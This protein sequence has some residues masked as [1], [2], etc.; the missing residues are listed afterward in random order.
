MR[1]GSRGSSRPSSRAGG[2]L[3]ACAAAP[4]GPPEPAWLS[5][6]SDARPGL[7]TA[8]GEGATR[9]A[10]IDDALTRLAQR[11]E[12]RVIAVERFR[13][14]PGWERLDRDARVLS[15]V[16]LE[17]AR[18]LETRRG[19]RGHAALAGLDPLAVGSL[20]GERAGAALG[21]DPPRLPPGLGV[22][23]ERG[24]VMAPGA[25][26]WPSL[27]ERYGDALAAAPRGIDAPEAVAGA[28]RRV[29]GPGVRRAE[30]T[31]RLARSHRPGER[32]TAWR[33]SAEVGGAPRV[34]SGVT[35]D[36]DPARAAARAV[37]ASRGAR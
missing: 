22:W 1:R 27:R 13:E 2:G 5:A 7:W 10:A 34:W 6:P 24:A 14:G 21:A 11:V 20:Y 30:W 8:A 15:D 9:D 4:P 18:V 29:F 35:R 19:P 37:H 28:L 36:A 25:A 3:A 17:G 31:T 12:A 33:L 32:L 16:R 26:D 23:I